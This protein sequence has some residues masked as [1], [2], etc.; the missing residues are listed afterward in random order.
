MSNGILRTT[1]AV[2]VTGITLANASNAKNK[3]N[4]AAARVGYTR[5]ATD[6]TAAPSILSNCVIRGC[7]NA[8]TDTSKTNGVV[9][10]FP[11]SIIVDCVISNN[12]SAGKAAGVSLCGGSVMKKCLIADNVSTF[13]GAGFF[14]EGGFMRIEDCVISNNCSLFE[15]D[16]VAN[17]NKCLGGGGTCRVDGSRLFLK[18]CTFVGNSAK[19]GGGLDVVKD[20]DVFMEGCTF[21]SNLA[22]QCGGGVRVATTG[23]LY[24]NNCT[25]DGNCMTNTENNIDVGYGGGG[26]YIGQQ[27]VGGV[28]FCSISNSVF[29]GNVSEARGGG[30]GHTIG[31]GA[32]GEVVN[33]VFTNNV[34]YRQGGGLLLWNN[35]WSHSSSET[36]Y[37]NFLVRNCLFAYN[38]TRRNG[39]GQGG[40]VY[41][42]ASPFDVA[43]IDSCTIACNGVMSSDGGGGLFHR[44]GG[45]VTNTVIAFNTVSGVTETS[46]EWCHTNNAAAYSH[47]C[48][49]P[50]DNST[51]FTREYGNIVADP[52]FRNA[53]AYDFSLRP[54]SP[55]RNAGVDEDWMTGTLD[56]DG[57]S[58]I[59]FDCVDIGCFECEL[60]PPGFQVIVF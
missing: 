52:K 25:F 39:T 11:E 53:A 31:S 30:F 47:C 4:P 56:L 12:T 5:T 21:R 32:Y 19:C 26:V 1:R 51:Y 17:T 50:A 16:G 8:A 15:K 38:K 60:M 42:V 43:V 35:Q 46:A 28:G 13:Q 40:G 27:D 2:F 59:L 41:F 24:A 34:S 18:N 7:N 58:R 54:S 14:C 6:L 33:C 9:C 44:Y 45:S 49:W 10:A 20:V 22:W 29:C 48:V 36:R 3:D 55:C 57:K 23:R 37:L